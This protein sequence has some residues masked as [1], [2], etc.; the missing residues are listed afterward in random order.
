MLRM[1]TIFGME[2][3][4]H[5]FNISKDHSINNH[6]ST[7]QT[8]LSICNREIASVI[9]RFALTVIAKL[10][11]SSACKD[12]VACGVAKVELWVLVLQS[13]L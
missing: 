10:S 4:F 6:K 13:T 12:S 8:A 2:A 3:S 7:D 11:S 5:I 9:M 1:F